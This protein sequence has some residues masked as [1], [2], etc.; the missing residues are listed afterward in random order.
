MATAKAVIEC[1]EG[2]ENWSGGSSVAQQCG[3]RV[4]GRRRPTAFFTTVNSRMPIAAA[5]AEARNAASLSGSCEASNAMPQNAQN[6]PSP[7]LVDA[8]IHQRTQLGAGQPL[9]RRLTTR[10]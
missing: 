1:P 4:H 6:Q 8:I 3:S 7:P 5:I 9:T 10:S 2:N